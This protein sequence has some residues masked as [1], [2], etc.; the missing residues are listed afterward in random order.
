MLFKINKHIHNLCV[1][2]CSFFSTSDSFSKN[3]R[4]F[5]FFFYILSTF[6]AF[7]LKFIFLE[8][9]FVQNF[10]CNFLIFFFLFHLSISFILRMK[11]FKFYYN[12]LAASNNYYLK[13]PSSCHPK[14][15]FIWLSF[16]YTFYVVYCSRR[17][18]YELNSFFNKNLWV[19]AWISY[20]LR[21]FLVR[22]VLFN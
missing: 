13:M 15:T 11:L 21:K 9:N 14:T 20:Y 3:L 7:A 5:Q 8:E 2:Y 4:F 22:F 18:V 10:L 19:F 16:S 1:F 17:R 6:Q 12:S